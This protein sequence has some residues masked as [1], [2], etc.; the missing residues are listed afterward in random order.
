MESADG[1]PLVAAAQESD[2]VSDVGKGGACFGAVL[3]LAMDLGCGCEGGD[4]AADGWF[5]DVVEE[6]VVAG[7][8]WAAVEVVEAAADEL[9]DAEVAEVVAGEQ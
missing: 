7:G 1:R 2:G 5:E 8:G 9:A 3:E 6:G 4:L